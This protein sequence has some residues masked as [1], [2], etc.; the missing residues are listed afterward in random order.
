M[1]PIILTIASWFA[2]GIL[3]LAAVL[4]WFAS[5][6][7]S[8]EAV[9]YTET[10]RNADKNVARQGISARAQELARTTAD[11]RARLYELT[12]RDVLSAAKLIESVGPIAHVALRVSGATHGTVASEAEVSPLHVVVFT[13][14][15]K[16]SFAHILH[17][18]ELLGTLPMS[19]VMEQ[20][21]MAQ[22]PPDQKAKDASATWRMNGRIRLLTSAPLPS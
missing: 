6:L 8:R 3:A 21:D 18:E 5:D 10:A 11:A 17:A 20:F 12:T 19:S 22:I 9:A 13:F 15:A 7:L 1:R 4:W 14:E 2:V 16:G